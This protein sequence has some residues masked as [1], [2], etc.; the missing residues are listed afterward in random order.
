V[1]IPLDIAQ[2][3]RKYLWAVHL[4]FISLFAYVAARIANL[5]VEAEIVSLRDTELLRI[6]A[7]DAP[8][9]ILT[10]LGVAQ[11]AKLTGLTVP[12]PDTVKPGAW[13]ADELGSQPIQSALRVKLLGTLLAVDPQWSLASILDLGTSRA[14]TYW[15]GDKLEGAEIL[16]IERDRAIILN[17]HRREYIDG[18]AAVTSAKGDEVPRPS[19]PGTGIRALS[20]N[21]YEISRREIDSSLANFTEVATQARIVPVS[22]DGQVQGFKLF[23]IRP[24]SIYS[25]VGIQNGDVIRKINGYELNSVEKALELYTKLKEAN[26]IDIEYERAGV[27]GH[28]TY[29]IH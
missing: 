19:V 25:K 23:S 4:V 8:P 9:R 12:E 29:N 2:Q 16:E 28:R 1:W 26:R 18:H 17:N 6:V 5:A 7:R 11:L 24:D 22:K 21:E 10:P 14:Q 15:I 27:K 3:S 13:A 20:E